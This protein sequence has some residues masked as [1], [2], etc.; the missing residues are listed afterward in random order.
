MLIGGAWV[1]RG[2]TIDVRNPYDGRLV[3]TVPRGCAGDIEDAVTAAAQSAGEPWPAH[4]R[5]DVLTRAAARIEADLEGYARTIALEGSKSIREARHEPVRCV[6]ILRL[7]AEEGR[8]LAGET[9][10][11]DSRTGSENRVGYYFRFP[12]GV[13]GA[14]T[15][16]NDPL[17][18]ACHKVAPAL[19]GGNAV[20][21]KPG[22]ATPLSALRLAHDLAEAG[23]PPGRLNVVTGRGEELGGAIVTNPRVRLVT[24]TGGVETGL[25]ITRTAGVKKLCM[26]LGSNSP[27]LVMPDADLGRAVPAIA[28]GAFAQAGQNCLGVQRVYLLSDVYDAFRERFVAHVRTLEAGSSMDETTDVCAM[29]TTGQAERVESWIREA[30]RGGARVLTGG[31]REGA[32]LWPTVLESVP[33]GARL[34][35]DEAYGPVVSLYRVGTLGEAI[36]RA[37]TVDYGLHAAIFTENLRAAFEAIRGL[38]VGGVMVNDS[39]DYRLDVMPFGG[40]K[41]SGIGREGIR[42]ALQEMTETRV[43][44][45]NL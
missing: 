22:T 4:A 43:V 14:I 26:E 3:D 38:H 7:A 20:V 40:T 28:A 8:R 37:N 5:Y 36:T 41:L 27:V 31:R 25:R 9:L 42:F 2:E 10:P 23:L 32:L 34:D 35:C 39:T 6:T 24:F 1:G 19:A 16:F 30:E 44:C 11:F 17:A 12:V 21:L 33:E 13:V 15:P 45:F 18:M 29:I